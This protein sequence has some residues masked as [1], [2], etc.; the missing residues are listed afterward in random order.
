[1]TLLQGFPMSIRKFTV[2]EGAVCDL[3]FGSAL[4]TKIFCRVKDF[5]GV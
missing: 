3:A 5:P 2:Q 4:L 1:M